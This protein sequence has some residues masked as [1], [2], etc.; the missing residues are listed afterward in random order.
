PENVDKLQAAI[1]EELQRAL[2]KGFDQKEVDE[3]VQ[4]LL[5]YRQ[6]ARTRDG[7]LASTWIHYMDVGRTFAWSQQIDEAL[8]SLTADEVNAALREALDPDALSTA[9]AGDPEKP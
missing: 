7:V 3:G 9:I 4:A 5:N 6:L 1:T 2:E 8:Q